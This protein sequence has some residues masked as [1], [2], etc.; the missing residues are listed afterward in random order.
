[1]EYSEEQIQKSIRAAEQFAQREAN[2]KVFKKYAFHVGIKREHLRLG[3][4]LAKL[5]DDPLAEKLLPQARVIVAMETA[6]EAAI[7]ETFFGKLCE[8]LAYQQFINERMDGWEKIDIETPFSDELNNKKWQ[9][10][11]QA[12]SEGNK[13]E[14]LESLMWLMSEVKSD[15]ITTDLPPVAPG[16]R[17]PE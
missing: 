4:S 12:L 15:L 16:Y 2:L 8:N 9:R 5:V 13:I 6:R 14:L 11:R 10:F 7:E 3:D 1:M 17:I